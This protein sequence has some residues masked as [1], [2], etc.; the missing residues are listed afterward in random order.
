MQ[1]LAKM[2]TK[3]SREFT[4]ERTKTFAN[5]DLANFIR[6]DLVEEARKGLIFR[7]EEYK[8]KGSAGAGNWAAVPWLAFFDPLITES[9]QN[10][11]YVVFLINVKSEAIYLSLNQGTTAV[12]KEFGERKGK[13]VLR[14]R[15]QD[16]RD[17]LSD[18]EKF[19]PV[20]EISLGSDE[21]LPAG[22]EAGH[23]MGAVFHSKNIEQNDLDTSLKIA[24]DAY[25]K[26]IDRGGLTPTD[27]MLE[28][29]GSTDIE[30]SRRYVLS[31]RIE[32]SSTVR[33]EVLSRVK[34]ICEA[35]GL[36][37]VQ[38]Y[39][40]QGKAINTPLDVHHLVELRGLA[41]GET[42]RYKVPDD[43]AVLCPSCHR[44]IHKQSDPSDVQELVSLIKFK[45]MRE[46]F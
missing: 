32:R 19:L 30:E 31:R 34:A 37:P 27:S 42:K 39:S 4:F 17:R 33:R 22:Y 44:M 18:F 41:E 21:S 12:Y 10:G 23:A 6:R 8:L 35:C 28:Q 14:R 9:A 26:L 16:I 38:D 13:D 20:H 46:A 11:F 1:S 36:D 2:L 43:F 15:A 29:A 3:I 5:N 25:Q 24:L 40:Y 45:H 7:D